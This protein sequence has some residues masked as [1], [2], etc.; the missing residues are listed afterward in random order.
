MYKNLTHLLYSIRRSTVYLLLVVASFCLW[1]YTTDIEIMFGNY[2]KLHTYTDMA[3]SGIMIL[4]FPL[5]LIALFYKSW[6]YWKR[7]DINWKTSTGIIWWV[8]G[9]II[10]GASCCGATL[11]ASFGLLPLM[12]FLPY[13]W[14]EIKIIGSIWLLYAL[15]DILMNLETCKIKK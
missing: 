5:F 6:K 7:A 1:Y 11:A 9:T 13:S 8:I 15:R 4:G 3:L 10:S 12:S 2:G 14:L